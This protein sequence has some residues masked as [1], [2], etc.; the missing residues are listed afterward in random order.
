[1][2]DQVINTIPPPTDSFIG[3]NAYS[4]EQAKIFFGRDEEIEQLT[5]LIKFN[6]LTILFGKSGT[7]KTSLLNAGI[8][9]GLRHDYCLPFRIRLEFKKDSPELITQV[10]QVLKK[11]IDS[12]GFQVQSYPGQETL[13]EYFHKEPLWKTITP[14]LIFD[15]FEEIFTLAGGGT[16]F[17]E[18]E[19]ALFWEELSD[20]IENFIPAS[21]KDQFLNR[22][23]EIDYDYNS[24][25]VKVLFSFREE[26]LAEFESFTE[27]IPSIKLSRFRLMPMNEKQAYQVVK[28]TWGDKINKLQAEKVVSY[29]AVEPTKTGHAI[30]TIEPSLLSQVCTYIEKERIKAGEKIITDELLNKYSKDYTLRA[31]YEEALAESNAVFRDPNIKLE[32]DQPAPMSIFVQEKL[33]TD[34]GF[35]TRYTISQNDKNELLPGILVLDKK[36]FLRLDDG[37]VELT[38]DVLA[39]LIKEDREKRRQKIAAAL[40]NKKA[41]RRGLAILLLCLLAGLL[42]YYLLT[43]RANKDKKAIEDRIEVLKNDSTNLDVSV[44]KLRSDSARLT[45][46]LNDA[47]NAN[48]VFANLNKHIDTLNEEIARLKF[49]DDSLQSPGSNNNLKMRLK[50]VEANYEALLNINNILRNQVAELNRRPAFDINAQNSKM[51]QLQ[52]QIDA[53]NARLLLSQTNY[54]KLQKEFDAYRLKYP[55]TFTPDELVAETVKK[56]DDKSVIV[57]LNF[58]SSKTGQV[59]VPD[60]LTVYLI[61]KTKANRSVINNTKIYEI[62]CNESTLSKA[63]DKQKASFYKGDYFFNSIPPG[64]Y[65]LKVC[66]YYGNY[67]FVKK[68]IGSQTISVPVS[69]PTQKK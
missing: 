16:H 5:K 60:N 68:D 37:V 52:N 6:T 30:T 12:Y 63:V 50:E 56:P 69:P 41:R 23:E 58:G 10:K 36:Y 28:N 45:P 43:R 51:Q 31:V 18:K 7:G 34:K 32:K 2:T 38:H 17:G 65:L 42:T 33:I 40:A 24:Q 11:E 59:A 67:S 25:R 1:M 21:L 9:P 14:I 53:L 46:D 20:L 39:P 57:K 8:F 3:L 22:K 19:F 13:W 55:V 62:G 35:R 44:K 29:F 54:E 61:P 49:L 64:T 26:Y 66:S 48:P 47:S 27:K 4:E 15:Q